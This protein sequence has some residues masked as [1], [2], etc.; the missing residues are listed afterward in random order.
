MGRQRA[1]DRMNA[2]KAWAPAGSMFPS[3]ASSPTLEQS[4]WTRGRRS[5]VIMMLWTMLYS[6]A[7]LVP[8][9]LPLPPHTL[10]L[11]S[12]SPRPRPPRR[13][14]RRCWPPQCHGRRH[15]GRCAA[16]VRIC[17]L[18]W[19]GRRQRAHLRPDPADLG[20]GG[21]GGGLSAEQVSW[22][23]EGRRKGNKHNDERASQPCMY[24]RM[25]MCSLNVFPPPAETRYTGLS[26]PTLRTRP[27]LGTQVWD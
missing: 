15:R 9:H 13:R 20:N 4:C 14:R 2:R 27:T 3:S 1:G 12:L 26:A 23:P 24:V 22:I 6:S 8:C 19:C 10:T 21:E 17:R 16:P 18:A 11:L 5:A 25:P 7:G